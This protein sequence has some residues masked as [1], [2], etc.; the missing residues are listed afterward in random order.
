VLLT[1]PARTE[2]SN[3]RVDLG[4]VILETRTT[5]LS[6]CPPGF[7]V[8]ASIEQAVRG[9][10]K[11]TPIISQSSGVYQWGTFRLQTIAPKTI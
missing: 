7:G 9:Q 4:F 3:Q 10:T 2:H 11:G 1:G 8:P 5:L 6:V